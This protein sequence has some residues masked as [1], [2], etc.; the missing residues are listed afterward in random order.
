M[1]WEAATGR[2]RLKVESLPPVGGGGPTAPSAHD[3]TWPKRR[4]LEGAAA[5]APRTTLRAAVGGLPLGLVFGAIGVAA[6]V[7]V[8]VLHL[9]RLGFSFCVFK[10]LTGCPCVT[11]GTTRALA[12]LAAGDW[13]GALAM[14]PLAAVAAFT[15]VP[16]VLADLV[17]LPKGRALD[18]TL[19]PAA[20]RLARWGTLVA[21]V[22]NW[23]YL[24]A[25][26]R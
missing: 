11:C 12:R 22:A 26:G 15:L 13:L 20:A 7:A 17:L 24:I 9:D 8:R 6:A 2:C 21:L 10:A 14:N 18:L 19:S 5:E 25:A 4:A 3:T 16:W 1:T 23:A